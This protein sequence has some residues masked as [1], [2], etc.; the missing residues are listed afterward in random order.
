[1]STS[2]PAVGL[3]MIPVL[4]RLVRFR[5]TIFALPFALAGALM[6]RLEIPSVATL[7]WILLAMVG[8]R[9][10]AMAV[11]RLVDARI[12]ALNPRTATRE[13]PAGAVTRAQVIGFSAASLAA[14][15]VAVSQLPEITWLLWPIP[16]AAFAIYPFTKRFTW[17]CH[18]FLGA[19]IGLA[20][21][22]AWMAV[23]GGIA[24]AP[25]FLGL[26][27]ATWIAG[28][29]IIYALLDVEFD[30][31][32]GIQSVPARFGRERALWFTRFAHLAAIALLVAAGV[33]AGA[34]VVYLLGVAACAAVLLYENAIVSP[35]DPARI[36][37]AFGTANG[38]LAM[39]FVAFVI[40]EVA[41]S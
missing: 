7:G 25:V 14:L 31:G 1:V 17:G 33:A 28:F 21:V 16:V 20:P 18:F 3:G 2:A 27:V 9:S 29:D 4:G 39:I 19:T 26:A 36:Q 40:A 41:L 22:G 6:A 37:A 12:D 24:W 23:T 5:H 38:V 13:I 32:H 30:R 35:R 10:L 15:L 8:A 34:G 11:N